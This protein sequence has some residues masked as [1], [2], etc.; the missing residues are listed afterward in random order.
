MYQLSVHGFQIKNNA[1]PSH[2]QVYWDLRSRLWT[3]NNIALVD[4]KLIIPLWLRHPILQAL[5]SAHQGCTNMNAHANQNIYWPGLNKATHHFKDTCNTHIQH[6]PAPPKEPIIL[7]PQLQRP[8]QMMCGDYFTIAGH[9]Y[10]A[11]VDR[12]WMALHISLW[13]PATQQVSHSSMN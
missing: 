4:H 9:A 2:L 8:F 5:H 13:F 7:S 10:M 1:L 3:W 11:I 12:Y 6:T